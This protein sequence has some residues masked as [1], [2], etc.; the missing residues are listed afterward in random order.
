VAFQDHFSRQAAQYAAHRPSYPA[1]L[2]A[3]LASRAPA[4]SL[5]WDA[6]CGSGQAALG[7]AR[8][9]ARVEASDPSERQIA[10]APNHPRIRYHVAAE[11]LPA[12]AGASVDLITAAQ[13]LHWFDRDPF[14]N[15]ARRVAAPDAVIAAWT[16]SLPR[17]LPG[18]DAAIDGLY[19]ELDP[20]WP[21]GRR[22]V[23]DGY[24]SITLPGRPL[25][26]P[27][28]AMTADWT[29]AQ[30]LGYLASWSAVAR[31]RADTGQDAVAR[32][33]PALE[34]AWGDPRRRHPVSWP[35]VMRAARL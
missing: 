17:V 16:Y 10:Q 33:L 32:A 25:P 9:F 23:E 27:V 14:W 4:T 15:E 26:A 11:S 22:A 8:H 18:I 13:A 7:L 35:L 20:W 12:L 1:D 29:L 28:F 5:A 3:W 2:H 19:A 21:P 30:L 6:G 31:H 34:D 24:A